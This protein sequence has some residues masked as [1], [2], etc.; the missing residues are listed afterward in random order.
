MQCSLQ[1][2]LHGFSARITV[3]KMWMDMVSFLALHIIIFHCYK[4]VLNA[5]CEFAMVDAQ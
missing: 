4:D 5:F 3:T 1:C 2:S